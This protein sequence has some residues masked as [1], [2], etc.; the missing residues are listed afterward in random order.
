ME[1]SNNP[2]QTP[3][4]QLTTAATQWGEVRFFSPSLRIG[5]LRFLS[6][7]FLL[8]LGFYLVLIAGAGLAV[9]VSPIFWVMFA[10]GYIAMLVV[11][12]ILMIQRLHDL[13]KNGWLSLLMI[14]PLVNLFF[15]FYLMFAP[16][17]QGS[18]HYGLQPPPNKTWN[19]VLGLAGPILGGLAM[20]G[21]IAAIAIPAYQDY[22][23]RVREQSYSQDHENLDYHNQDYNSQDYDES[24]LMEYPQSLELD[25]D[26]SEQDQ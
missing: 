2:Y 4:G 3:A 6:H 21:I 16:G 17:T 12:F 8:V 25:E 9:N 11:I 7:W 23:E 20:I 1:P 18:N 10:A 19:W 14:V 13:N 22:Q 24:E 26:G 15:A 5:R